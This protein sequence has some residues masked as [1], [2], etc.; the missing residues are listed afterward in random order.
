MTSLC[1]QARPSQQRT[2]TARLTRHVEARFWTTSAH[3]GKVNVHLT[4]Q[5]LD[6][7]GTRRYTFRPEHLPE[8]AEAIAALAV[9][10]GQATAIDPVLRE[11]LRVL[12]VALESALKQDSFSG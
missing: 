4:L 3:H 12:G 6:P 11:E 1:T 10:F 9:T 2:I 7:R 5:R 8:L